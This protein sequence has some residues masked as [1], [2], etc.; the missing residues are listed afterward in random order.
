[1]NIFG[2]K[3]KIAFGVAVTKDGDAD[4]VLWLKGKLVWGHEDSE[5]LCPVKWSC[6]NFLYEL[7]ENYNSILCRQVFPGGMIPQLTAGSYHVYLEKYLSE[8]DSWKRRNIEKEASR[9]SEENNLAAW[10]DGIYVDEVLLF[11]LGAV[12]IATSGD[13]VVAITTADLKKIIDGLGD[14]LCSGL[15]DTEYSRHALAA[16][17][18]RHMISDDDRIRLAVGH[19]VPDAVIALLKQRVEITDIGLDEET[20]FAVAARM[21][22]SASVPI[23]AI[24]ELFEIIGGVERGDYAKLSVQRSRLAV[25]CKI[26]EEDS[27]LEGYQLADAVR[28][29]LHASDVMCFPI[30]NIV[31]DVFGVSV[32]EKRFYR[33]IDAVAV[34]GKVRGPAIVVNNTVNSRTSTANGRRTALA[35]ELC[36][37]LVDY[38]FVLPVAE[39][40][41]GNTPNEIEKR[42]NAFAAELLLPRHIAFRKAFIEERIQDAIDELTSQYKVSRRVVMWQ[43]YNHRDFY[44]L[45][46][47]KVKYIK[48]GLEPYFRDV[49]AKGYFVGR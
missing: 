49:N 42:A 30:E 18:R 26:P 2:D 13:D 45:P 8:I 25:H 6:I 36:H 27:Y 29:R 5:K 15:D 20:E 46:D 16:W 22:L 11:R 24:Q 23:E 31:K 39:V 48:R 33:L 17:S 34:W 4:F 10:F 7:G 38:R 28:K 21:A 19:D 43:I 1:M 47:Y 9:F 35:H 12:S 41:C 3:D 44:G 32:Y 37:L 14:F 40:L